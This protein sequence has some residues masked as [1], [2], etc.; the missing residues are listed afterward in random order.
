MDFSTMESTDKKD[1]QKMEKLPILGLTL[2][3]P[4]G[5]GP[6]IVAATAVLPE[7]LSICRPIAIGHPEI[8]HYAARLRG[9]SPKIV[10]VDTLEEAVFLASCNDPNQSPSPD[11]IL[12]LATGPED[13]IDAP[14]GRIDAR[15]GNAAFMAVTTAARAAIAGKI[16]G[17]VTAPLHKEALHLAGHHY[18]GH[19]E[20]LA[21]MCGVRDF[22]MMLYLGPDQIVR[23]PEGLA[24]VH[25]TLHTAMR[26]VFEEMTPIAIREKTHLVHDFMRKMHCEHPRIAVCALNCHNGEGGLFGDEEIRVI[27]PAVESCCREG[28]CVDGPLSVDTIFVHARDGQYDAVVAMYHDQGHIALKLIGMHRAVNITLGLPIIRT[29]VAHGTAFDIAWQGTAK[30]TSMIEAIRCATNLAHARVA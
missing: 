13:A 3:D 29:S 18:P 9:I 6:E 14:H 23:S 2:G 12:C 16:D 24:V 26:N 30:I 15:S 25:V 7:V 10:A 27:R 8:L 21:E 28:L 17:I 19:T 11:H 1:V 5:V 4:S 20:L 22:A